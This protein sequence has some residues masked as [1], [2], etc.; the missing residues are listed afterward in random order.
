MAS[1]SNRA[2]FTRNFLLM[3][4]RHHTSLDISPIERYS[5]TKKSHSRTPFF[6]DSARFITK[7]T[8]EII[9]DLDCCASFYNWF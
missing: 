6:G 3:I 1:T 5:R 2:K 7:R 8:D 4:S 9:L